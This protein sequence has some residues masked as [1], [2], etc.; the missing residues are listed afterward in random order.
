MSYPNI[1]RRCFGPQRFSY[2]FPAQSRLFNSHAQR[3]F[4][5]SN[6][7]IQSFSGPT[8][9]AIGLSGLGI[10]LSV[11]L[12]PSIKCEQS[13]VSLYELGFG[14]V[15]GICAG[16]FIKKGAKTIA[17]FLGGVFVLLQYLGSFSLLRVD[18]G[19]VGQRFE[20]L[21]YTKDAQ[22]NKKAP[23]IWTAWLWLVDFLT[24]DFQPRASFLAGLG[25]GLRIG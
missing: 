24:A 1:F 5:L 22:G 11:Y 18:W 3:P 25:L 12:Q 8:I 20:S 9:K 7:R 16:V 15:A 21:F 17:F 23:T 19:R 13:S 2:L 14:T 6:P 4:S 10:G